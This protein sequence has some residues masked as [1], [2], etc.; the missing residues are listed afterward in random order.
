MRVILNVALLFATFSCLQ[1]QNNA[2][3]RYNQ[4]TW[5]AEMAICHGRYDSAFV[6]YGNAFRIH[7]G[8]STDYYNL[9]LLAIKM[10]KP[11]ILYTCLDSLASKGFTLIDLQKLV[12]TTYLQGDRWSSMLLRIKSDI[13]KF[14]QRNAKVKAQLDSMVALD[15]KY[16]GNL[17]N[18][19]VLLVYHKIVY[20]NGIAI[21]NLLK[22]TSIAADNLY[23]VDKPFASHIPYIIV[24]HYLGLCH[25][26][27]LKDSNLT[28]AEYKDMDFSKNDLNAAL[29]LA[30][31][32][33]VITPFC[34][35]NGQSAWN[36][37]EQNP[38]TDAEIQFF[39]GKGFVKVLTTEQ[40]DV[41]NISR[42]GLGLGPLSENRERAIR[43]GELDV[44]GHRFRFYLATRITYYESKNVESIESAKNALE[45]Q[46]WKAIN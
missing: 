31:K 30:V 32:K 3:I 41:I 21:I 34:L 22:N 28:Y 42:S 5:K 13:H 7:R 25:Q 35:V 20:Q 9:A 18:D 12:P 16:A 17:P 37:T 24:H 6:Y 33:G 26:L 38:Y 44:S 29:I 4:E 45:K 36:N 23:D 14:Q 19:T 39:N 40:Q 27:L 15:Q 8:W 2:G 11:D 1:A 43:E 10:E 46:G